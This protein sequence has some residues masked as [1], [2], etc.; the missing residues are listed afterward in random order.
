MAKKKQITTVTEIA[1]LLKLFSDGKAK[2]ETAIQVNDYNVDLGPAHEHARLDLNTVVTEDREVDIT[3]NNVNFEHIDEIRAPHPSILI[4]KDCTFGPRMIIDAGRVLMERCKADDLTIRSDFK[5]V[6]IRDSKPGFLNN[7]TINKANNVAMRSCENVGTLKISVITGALDIH[8]TT[9]A[10][11]EIDNCAYYRLIMDSSKCP[12]LEIRNSNIG[13]ATLTNSEVANKF[14]VGNTM[15]VGRMDIRS[16]KFGTMELSQ[17]AIIGDFMYEPKNIE[18]LVTYT[19]VGISP[20][21]KDFIMYKSCNVYNQA[22]EYMDRIIVELSVPVHA[23]RVYCG[24]LKIRVSEAKVIKFL[25]LN[26][27]PYRTPRNHKV[28]S[29]HDHGF[30]YKLGKSVVPELK[31][32]KT[33]GKCGSGIHGFVKFVDAVNYN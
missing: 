16:S 30:V 27:E 10:E 22:D 8:N 7:V 2:R 19:S 25:K 20:P 23:D 18:N 9:M 32:C 3:F 26:G 15:V 1:D 28:C 31:F 29:A 17:A 13:T 5:S 33:S 14:F 4:F 12:E 21:E 24:H 6:T 11:M